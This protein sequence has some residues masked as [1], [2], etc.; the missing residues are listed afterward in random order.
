MNGETMLCQEPGAT[1]A[2][3]EMTLTLP[4]RATVAVEDV[5]VNCFCFEISRKASRLRRPL[6]GLSEIKIL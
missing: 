2:A 4:L 5:A 6:D 1:R 3:A